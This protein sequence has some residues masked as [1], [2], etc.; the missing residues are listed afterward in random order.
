[1]DGVN[2]ES[3]TDLADLDLDL[4]DYLQS[5]TPLE[6]LQRHDQAL[7]LVRALRR[8]GAVHYGVDP[9]SLEAPDGSPR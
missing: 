6:R 4:L 1:M 3:E 2:R 9:R 5:L 8:A 7:E